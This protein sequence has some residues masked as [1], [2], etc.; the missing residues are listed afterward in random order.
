MRYKTLL[1]LIESASQTHGTLSEKYQELELLVTSEKTLWLLEYLNRHE[2]RMAETFKAAKDQLNGFSDMSLEYTPEWSGR[3]LVG[4][5]ECVNINDVDSIL[6]RA[7][8]VDSVVLEGLRGA[9]DQARSERCRELMQH[10]IN[11]ATDE[12]RRVATS[13]VKAV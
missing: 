3:D 2:I 9:R 4:E 10:L 13:L 1:D 7:L 11:M 8:E 12:Q 5:L 6:S